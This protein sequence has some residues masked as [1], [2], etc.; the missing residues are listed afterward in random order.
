VSYYIDLCWPG[1]HHI[2]QVGLELTASQPPVKPPKDWDHR[3]AAP[4]CLFVFVLFY[5]VWVFETGF[6]V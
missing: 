4:F 6:P 2:D 3:H 5:F 1:E